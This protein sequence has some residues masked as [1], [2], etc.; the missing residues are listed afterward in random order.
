MAGATPP[1]LRSEGQTN[2]A[3]RS[4]VRYARPDLERMAATIVADRAA[5]ATLGD[6]AAR[7]GVSVW[8]VRRVLADAGLGGRR[9]AGRPVAAAD[10]VP[11]DEADDD[12]QN[13][14]P[15]AASPT[16]PDATDDSTTPR[17]A[18]A[19]SATDVVPADDGST[20]QPPDG[21]TGTTSPAAQ[22]RR[23]STSVGGRALTAEEIR[24]LRGVRALNAPRAQ[25]GDELPA[26]LLT[27]VAQL[28]TEGA[29]LADL[30][31]VL[32]VTTDTVINLLRTP[33]SP[34]A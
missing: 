5:G 14:A 12:T 17:A 8:A 11:S 18:I 7:H 1:Q 16:G 4:L 6:L 25:C 32:E 9:H 20:A 33:G 29:A 28:W 3:G 15:V 21:G 23:R 2:G 22:Q 27:L 13:N 24:R 10:S 19:D 31:D 34:A 26:R 30:A